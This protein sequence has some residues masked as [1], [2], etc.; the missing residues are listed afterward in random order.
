MS[1]LE[2]G[3]WSGLL[4]MSQCAPPKEAQSWDSQVPGLLVGD[5]YLSLIFLGAY[6][7]VHACV[8]SY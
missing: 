1:R 3:R 5:K 4:L 7:C 6:V 8:F 2:F